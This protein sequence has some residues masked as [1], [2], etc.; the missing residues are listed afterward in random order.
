M[1]E[2]QSIPSRDRKSTGE[3]AQHGEPDEGCV[4]EAREMV[5]AKHIQTMF[6]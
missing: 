1:N 2:S 4:R 3:S 6:G 5:T